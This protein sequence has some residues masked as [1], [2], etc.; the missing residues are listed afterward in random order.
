[1]IPAERIVH[2]YANEITAQLCREV[3]R[4]Q[5]PLETDP[6]ELPL[7]VRMV[8]IGE[9]TGLRIALCFLHGWHPDV[10]SDR[11]GK[12]DRLVIT[13]WKQHHPEE[14]E[15]DDEPT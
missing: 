3:V 7:S 8:L 6:L 1:M 5:R 11:D 10:E 14:W 4:R 15:D 2:D 12:A 9:I 13:W